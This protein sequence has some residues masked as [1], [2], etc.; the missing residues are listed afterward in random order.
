M[1]SA[2]QRRL[3]QSS[4]LSE[5]KPATLS[6]A[7]FLAYEAI[8][9]E[10]FHGRHR[11]TQLGVNK[12]C[13]QYD[14]RRSGCI[15]VKDFSGV[16]GQFLVGI[17]D[18][19][20]A[21]I[22]DLYDADVD[23]DGSPSGKVSL[24]T[25]ASRLL[26]P[27]CGMIARR[28]Q[29]DDKKENA[30]GTMNAGKGEVLPAYVPPPVS[31]IPRT[32]SVQQRLAKFRAGVRGL[33]ASKAPKERRQIPLGD[34][35]LFHSSS[36][37]SDLKAQICRK[38]IMSVFDK[39]GGARN[40]PCVTLENWMK[41]FAYITRSP[42]QPSL[43]EDDLKELYS[44]CE[45][46][47]V[48]VFIDSLFP[49]KPTPHELLEANK[50]YGNTESVYKHRRD[51]C[52]P[53]NVELGTTPF[54]YEG[55]GERRISAPR[56]AD[57]PSK[58]VYR[59]SRTPVAPP[60]GFDTSS[61]ALSGRAPVADLTLEHIQGFKGDGD[62]CNLYS[63]C[64]G[65][66]LVYTIAAVAVVYSTTD[67]SQAFFRE[68]DDDITC[69]AV[70]EPDERARGAVKAPRAASG[71]MG[72]NPVFYIWNVETCEALYKLGGKGVFL[73]AVCGVTFSYDGK[74]V[75]AVGMDDNHQIGVWNLVGG[76][77]KDTD[78]IIP[79]LLCL[80]DT[81]AGTPPMLTKIVWCPFSVKV[82]ESGAPASVVGG[83]RP[84]SVKAGASS[85]RAGSSR[86]ASVRAAASRS[87]SR[88]SKSTGSHR[89]SQ[90]L[91]TAGKGKHLKFWT[92]DPSREK[93][94]PSHPYGP[95]T[96]KN[97]KFNQAPLPKVVTD[98]APICS[99]DDK[100]SGDLTA[101][102]GNS[103]YIY[104]F[105]NSTATC[106]AFTEAHA[107]HPAHCVVFDHVDRRIY[108]G[109]GDGMVHAWDMK[110]RKMSE[111]TFDLN[112]PAK[113]KI[114]FLEDP[115]SMENAATLMCKR[116]T[117]F[118]AAKREAATEPSKMAGPKR[119]S[120][121]RG[122]GDVWNQPGVTKSKIKH[123][124]VLRQRD[125]GSA[126]K[127]GGEE[128]DDEGKASV[129][130][131]AGLARGTISLIDVSNGASRYV[132][133]CR[134][135]HCGHVYGLVMHPTIP[136]LFVTVGED[137]YICLW[138]LKEQAC[139]SR[140]VLFGPAKSA[141]ICPDGE[142]IAVGMFN[143][144][145]LIM[146]MG[147]LLHEKKRD[148]K[149][150]HVIKD[151]EEDI[152]DLK[153]SPDGSML[154]V[155]SHDNFVDVYDVGAAYRRKWRFKGHTS[156]VTHL[157]W[158]RDSRIIQSNC[159]AYEILYW[160]VKRGAQIRST[161]DSLEADTD[162]AT[163]TCVLGFPVMGVWPVDS[164]GTD[165]NSLDVCKRRELIVTA[166]D[167]GGVNLMRWPAV[168]KAA[169]RKVYGGHAAHVMNVRFSADDEYVVSVGGKDRAGKFFDPLRARRLDY[170]LFIESASMLCLWF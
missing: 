142:E 114:G 17:P 35:M 39:V 137:C 50:K 33:F 45:S 160:D 63:V 120:N 70:F 51:A 154:A 133:E 152:D 52:D 134:T 167:F 46:G 1:V 164:D 27:D 157:D 136:N 55:E 10:K 64:S 168:A 169:A 58:I 111:L 4:L 153:F 112:P 115:D 37:N 141:A 65:E 41:V 54:D 7:Q 101:V 24:K 151:C 83:S 61:V 128:A 170:L 146:E 68:H 127:G 125:V 93:L 161:M 90:A 13:S 59:Y 105:K 84:G 34:R 73:R 103:G 121:L 156:Y 102:C 20:V 123:L 91:V 30:P 144:V 131:A 100:R 31:Q 60:T 97:A 71:Q 15:S 92:F 113:A 89:S 139:S 130:L 75:A 86:A 40:G 53:G 28:V 96:F 67:N 87:A 162:F 74:H 16:L 148:L 48:E 66:R 21:G 108:T 72:Q 81:Q 82:P 80:K 140:R 69:L 107:M 94:L 109:G 118:T 36:V 143:G 9:R 95:L 98:C 145:L 79:K 76:K 62:T 147:E 8:I 126:E 77:D 22:A 11:N 165:V 42:T 56:E 43:H 57:V 116:K 124:A 2:V 110:L 6:D 158:S 12:L 88:G 166:D 159:G 99:K 23:P 32:G 117:V 132:R 138:D 26:N 14:P 135:G 104:L 122:E 47:N 29:P 149:A 25:F 19:D 78:E 106:V 85:R 5:S 155:G 119:G 150:K 44:N 18:R 129:I 163:W 3:R 38:N 49:P